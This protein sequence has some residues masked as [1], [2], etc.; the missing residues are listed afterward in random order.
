M[1]I[2]TL[3]VTYTDPFL[4]SKTKGTDSFIPSLL[5][6]Y[7]HTFPCYNFT[8]SHPNR[9]FIHSY[10]LCKYCLPEPAHTLTEILESKK[11]KKRNK[12]MLIYMYSEMGNVLVYNLLVYQCVSV[13][14]PV[15]GFRC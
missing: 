13:S 14:M 9:G 8:H 15:I 11:K 12:L 10:F 6:L 3:R 4:A 5:L 2:Y 1:H 7:T